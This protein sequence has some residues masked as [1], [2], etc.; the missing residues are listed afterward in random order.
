MPS[1]RSGSIHGFCFVSKPVLRIEP[2]QRRCSTLTGRTL[3]AQDRCHT[4]SDTLNPIREP[5]L[6]SQQAL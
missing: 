5:K 1:W 4:T 6:A 3:F 2:A